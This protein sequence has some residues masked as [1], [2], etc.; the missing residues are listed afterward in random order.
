M[1]RDGNS[2]PRFECQAEVGCFNC[3]QFAIQAFSGSLQCKLA[4]SP[5]RLCLRRLSSRAPRKIHLD[6]PCKCRRRPKISRSLCHSST[7]P[8]VSLA[9]GFREPSPLEPS[10]G[11][12][13]LRTKTA[14][15]FGLHVLF[16]AAAESFNLLSDRDPCKGPAMQSMAGSSTILN[17]RNAFAF[18]RS[19]GV[20]TLGSLGIEATGRGE[21][22][23]TKS[24]SLIRSMSCHAGRCSITL[25]KLGQRAVHPVPCLQ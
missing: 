5:T 1:T 19:R 21:G 10:T 23:A 6:S 20:S 4:S 8:W 9:G 25:Q 17:P 15:G 18:A 3:Q 22:K 2:T 7:P 14:V 24:R 13:R 12:A 11:K 16:Q